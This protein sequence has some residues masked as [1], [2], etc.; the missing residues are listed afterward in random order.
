MNLDRHKDFCLKAN[1][2]SE[3]SMWI[4]AEMDKACELAEDITLTLDEQEAL[5][6]RMDKLLAR[7]EWEAK[8]I[9]KFR[10]DY[11][12]ILEDNNE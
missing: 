1:S 12:D 2:M 10:E 7:S 6:E 3:S 11:S 4:T 9:D 5:L 8:Q